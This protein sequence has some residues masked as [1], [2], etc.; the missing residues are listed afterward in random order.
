MVSMYKSHKKTSSR[1]KDRRDNSIR[2]NNEKPSN[3]NLEKITQ[4][5]KLAFLSRNIDVKVSSHKKV[6]EIFLEASRKPDPKY[7][8]KI[9]QKKVLPLNLPHPLIKIYGKNS[10]NKLDR[11]V[12]TIN[13]KNHCPKCSKS[14]T[15]IYRS[16]Q[17]NLKFCTSCKWPI[18]NI[19]EQTKDF[20]SKTSQKYKSWEKTFISWYLSA[21]QQRKKNNKEMA[22]RIAIPLIALL[23]IFGISWKL[24]YQPSYPINYDASAPSQY[25]L[26]KE[27][28]TSGDRP[29][30]LWKRQEGVC[31]YISRY[32]GFD[33]EKFAQQIKTEYGVKCVNYLD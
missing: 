9:V 26:Y 16:K 23:V 7:C 15:Y 13:V 31:L 8:L 11:W 28:S 10:N 21:F 25:F 2:N 18:D 24:I 1:S 20:V 12:Q 5:L 33:R 22:F 14:V 19:F 29:T 32:S 4:T 6:L 3:V 17:F 30:L 27:I